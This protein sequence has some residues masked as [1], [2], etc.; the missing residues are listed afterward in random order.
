EAT[1]A[2]RNFPPDTEVDLVWHTHEGSY[3]QGIPVTTHPRPDVLPTVVTDADGA[4]EFPFEVP[5]SRGS[6]RPIS[7]EVEGRSVAVA[8]FVVQPSVERFG[9]RRGP[10]G[11]EI[12]I[13]LAGLGWTTF[14]TN[15]HL[16]YDNKPL[17]YVSGTA[18]EDT[19]STVRT[20]LPASGEPGYHFVDLY[21][22]IFD[23]Q[24]DDPDF[25]LKPHLSYVDNH[26]VRPMPAMHLAF[27]VTE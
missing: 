18:G 11:T 23:M 19:D 2:G 6:T 7:A 27:E 5:R 1:V 8:G 3:R 25:E 14:E 22:S 21:P 12:E 15:Y 20:T 9:P 10:V 4:F 17:G 24:D 26:P 16:V 13:E